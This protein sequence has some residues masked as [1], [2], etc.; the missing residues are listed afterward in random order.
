MSFDV[1]ILAGG[2]GTRLRSVVSE[3]PKCM[4]PVAGKPFLFYLLSSLRRYDVSRVVLSVG[5]LKESVFHWLGSED[6]SSVPSGGEWPFD[7]VFAVEDQPLGTGGGIRL[8]LSKCHEDRVVIL[9]GDTLFNV[10]LGALVAAH[11]R[12]LSTVS[13]E[14]GTMMALKPM[15]S[16]DRYGAVEMEKV[17]DKVG[18]V[19]SFKEKG[20]CEE[21]LINGGVYSIRKD[22]IDMSSHP[23]KFS[24]ENDFLVK[25]AAFARVAGMVSD[26]YFIDIGIPEDYG[27][28]QGE[29]KE[30]TA[31]MDLNL[32]SGKRFLFL[33]RDGVI[34]RQ[35]EGDYVREWSQF[36][37]IPGI[38]EA[39]GRWSLEFEKIFIVTNQRGV[40]RGLMTE[41][42][43][44]DIHTRMLEEIRHFGGR[45][46]G[47]YVSTS[48]D[49]SD[50]QRK[51]QT[52]LFE[53]ACA[54]FPE[55]VP[56][57]SVMIGDS[58]SDREFASN[59]GIEFVP[60]GSK[61]VV[62]K[63]PAGTISSRTKMIAR[64]TLFLY[65]R[66]FVLLVI[67]LFT[68][69]VVL[70]ALG[71]EDVGVYN[72]VAAMVTSFTIITN[73]LST[74]ISRF[75]TYGLGKN[76]VGDKKWDLHKV[77]S[78]GVVIEGILSG[79][80]LILVELVGVWF[81]NSHMNIPPERLGAANYVL[82]FSVLM[83]AANLMS[84]PFN[85][86]IIAH[87]KMK[88][89]AY[90]SLLEAVLK[91]G[92]AFA[93][94]LSPIDKLVTYSALMLFVSI[95][96]RAVYASYSSRF[97][98]CRGK[99]VFD[100]DIL[101]EMAG[102][103]G[104]NFFGSA[105]YLCN[106]QGIS[107]ITNIF[108]GVAVNAARGYAVQVEGIVRQFVTSFTT[109]LNPQITKSYA[110]GDRSYCYHLVCKGAKYSWILMLLFAVPFVFESDILMRLWLGDY[111]KYTDIFV[112]L[113]V[114]ANMVDMLGNSMAIL[115]MATGNIKKYYLIVGG[116]SFLVFPI[117]WICF[118]LGAAPESSYI[119]YIIVYAALVAI[120]MLILRRQIGFPSSM[121]GKEVL[122]RIAIVT[123]FS[124]AVTAIV[125]W[126]V[127]EGIYELLAVL[128][129]STLSIGCS[130]YL[131]ATTPG[132]KS[133]AD[134]KAGEILSRLKIKG[135][136]L[137]RD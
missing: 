103:A 3:V 27:K 110:E 38:R 5:Y 113:A 45:I 64:N 100:R 129:V 8:A 24:F 66:M 72:A 31:V 62:S 11:D 74:A 39:I 42:S 55:V 134:A 121:F 37:F 41:A 61:E 68:S 97:H 128:V 133:F 82:Q 105:S 1:I 119:V 106:T 16:F 22:L 101:K 20:Y 126:A 14:A 114:A 90:I 60:F 17:Y 94:Y 30:L 116:V 92:V 57:D 125:A 104:W 83:L 124:F 95:I 58:P 54:D 51:P 59:C 123:I 85:A 88:A 96:V 2:L 136:F 120:K 35:I 87:E 32:P 80:I 77:F 107:I 46:D 70:K 67:G 122:V 89:F 127:P 28:A 26:S 99:I 47:I 131:W 53:R 135:H 78:T 29:L 10:D 34:N 9:N 4:A 111:P 109:A 118:A 112:P 86:V 52:G 71:V 6:G 132:E 115:E 23:D 98:E 15:T 63:Q 65:F 50:H 75:I 12:S 33:D 18:K 79:I 130:T 40:G 108:F 25:E 7:I 91:L 117:S 56:E 43:L 48:T 84:V 49:P 36:E 73:S 137:N 19:L 76:Q 44:E 69:R 102:F 13:A 21:G 93:L 81:L